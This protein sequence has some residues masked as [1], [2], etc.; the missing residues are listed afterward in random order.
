MINALY[1]RVGNNLQTLDYKL[2][3]ELSRHAS[4]QSFERRRDCTEDRNIT[5]PRMLGNIPEKTLHKRLQGTIK[6]TEGYYNY[7]S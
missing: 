1:T 7:T 3:E 5:S 2:C 6:E 4:Q